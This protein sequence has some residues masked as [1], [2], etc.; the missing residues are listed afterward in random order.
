MLAEVRSDFSVARGAVEHEFAGLDPIE[1][2]DRHVAA[3]HRR[4]LNQI[5]LFEIRGF[6]RHIGRA[7]TRF[8][9]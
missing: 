1:I 5:R 9:P 6:K 4:K 8:W 7:K 2:D 3:R